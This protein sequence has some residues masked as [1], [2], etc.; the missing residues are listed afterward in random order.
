VIDAEDLEHLTKAA[1]DLADIKA[2]EAARAEVAAQGAIPWDQVKS[3][4]GL[5]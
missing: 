2:A 5:A 3:D 1:E 4:L